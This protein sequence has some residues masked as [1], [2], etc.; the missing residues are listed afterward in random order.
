MLLFYDLDEKSPRAVFRRSFEMSLISE[1]D[2]ELLLEALQMRNLLSHIYDDT[3]STKAKNLINN[4]YFDMLK[5]LHVML[6]KRSA[7]DS[8]DHGFNM[9]SIRHE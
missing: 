2:C 8:I 1:N 9:D 5:W 6:E 7:V 3:I 4:R